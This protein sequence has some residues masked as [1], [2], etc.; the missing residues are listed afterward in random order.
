MGKGDKW[1]KTDYK[2]FYS[3]FDSINFKKKRPTIEN[4]K[5]IKQKNKITYTYGS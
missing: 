5:E 1:R 3:N 2:N 4:R